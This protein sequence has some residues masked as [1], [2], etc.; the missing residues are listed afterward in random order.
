MI[1]I[2]EQNSVKVLNYIMENPD[3]YI[4]DIEDNLHINA[5]KLQEIGGDLEHSNMIEFKHHGGWNI[6][7]ECLDR[8]KKTKKW[9]KLDDA[10]YRAKLLDA[11]KKGQ[12][13]G[14]ET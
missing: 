9:I 3:C 4:E 1:E 2:R 8:F 13:K 7:D 5:K 12:I 10:D 6:T 11:Y 14:P